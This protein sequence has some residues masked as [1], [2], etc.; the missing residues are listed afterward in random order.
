MSTLEKGLKGNAHRLHLGVVGL[1][2]GND[3]NQI[4]SIDEIYIE[5]INKSIGLLRDLYPENDKRREIFKYI[6]GIK[7]IEEITK[8]LN[9]KDI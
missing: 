7:L 6:D 5:K 2:L 9:K 1:E 8:E 4:K 3:V